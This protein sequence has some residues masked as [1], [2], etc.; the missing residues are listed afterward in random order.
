MSASTLGAA[1]EPPGNERPPLKHQCVEKDQELGGTTSGV[2]PQAGLGRARSRLRARP[3]PEVRCAASRCTIS[4]HI[5]R[6]RTRW[7]GRRP[8][9]LKKKDGAVNNIVCGRHLSGEVDDAFSQTGAWKRVFVDLKPTVVDD[10]CTSIPLCDTFLNR[11]VDT[12]QNFARGH[13]LSPKWKGGQTLVRP[14]FWLL[15]RRH[16]G[17]ELQDYTTKPLAQ[18]HWE[19]E[20]EEH[21]NLEELANVPVRQMS[22]VGLDTCATTSAGPKASCFTSLRP[23]LPSKEDRRRRSIVQELL[24]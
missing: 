15:A 23:W 8:S 4:Q 24:E 13:R 12:V 9:D 6:K 1:E 14:V 17:L 10:V 3:T 16:P 2:A 11:K 18:K 19:E 5:H 7:R 22:H 20:Q 21:G